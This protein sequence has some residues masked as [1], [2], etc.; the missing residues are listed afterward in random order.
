MLTE[1][2]LLS[3]TGGALGMAVANQIAAILFHFIPQGH[4]SLVI[5][6]H[7]DRRALIFTFAVSVVTA[8][9]F[10]TAPAL[11]AGRVGLAGTLRADCSA[12]AGGGPGARIRG[13]LVVLQV[14]FSLIL[15]VAAGVFV[16]TVSALRPA[17]YLSSPDR[18][19]LFTIKPQQELYTDEQ[20]V[21]LAT[22]LLR[23]M[24]ALPG[25]EAVALAENGPLG[26]RR[27]TDTVETTGHE[28]MRA[29]CDTVTPGF[30][31]TV[32]IARIAGR[33]FDLRESRGGPLA[34]IVNQ[35]L[36]RT[37]F[38]NEN[39]I[40]KRLHIPLGK[41]DGTY[42]IVGVVA[43]THY[44][45]LHK[46]PG[47]FVWFLM[48][49]VPP[50]LPTLHVRT[51]SADTAGMITAVRREF[52]AIDKGF[53]VFNIRTMAARIEDSLAGERM[54]ANVSEAFGVLALALA[55]I[56]LYG[57]LSY[58]VSRRTR[59]IGICMAL[60]ARP[61]TLVWN[62]ARDALWLV[63]AGS[64]TGLGLALAGSHLTSHYLPD[65]SSFDPAIAGFCAL[66]MF[67]TAA[68]AVSVPAIRAFRINPVSALR[69]E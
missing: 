24:A 49:Q 57:I 64:A 59:E 69:Q 15:L 40:G 51:R 23:R 17:G 38:P 68:A 61:G 48:G 18:I 6:L 56:G 11:Q 16:R 46:A 7:P 65:V 60:G 22:E 25:V 26:S 35:A 19:L 36:A 10:G 14:A 62:I 30:F 20:R 4:I 55:A 8:L 5:D 27:S 1:S 32:G 21:R 53:P 42:E 34:V 28:A 44:Y 41:Q 58:T 50:Y 45:D 37:F 66:T 52:D 63:A 54:V 33:D 2:L 67:A 43:D 13:M 12:S 47:P 29:S 39:P 31:D 9:L 3:L